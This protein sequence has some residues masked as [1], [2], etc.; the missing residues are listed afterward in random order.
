MVSF[1]QIV[2]Q[3]VIWVMLITFMLMTLSVIGFGVGGLFTT[4]RE[5]DY[6]RCL[7]SA[8]KQ[9]EF[10]AIRQDQRALWDEDGRNATGI[11]NG[12]LSRALLSE[13]SGA[14]LDGNPSTLTIMREILLGSKKSVLLY[15][16]FSGICLLIWVSFIRLIDKTPQVVVDLRDR[17]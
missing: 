14:G 1:G 9:E 16:F 7:P 3:T 17:K 4:W 11:L 5:A 15:V 6:I 13:R 8:E 10:L 2:R 12:A